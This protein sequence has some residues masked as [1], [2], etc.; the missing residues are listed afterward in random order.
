MKRKPMPYLNTGQVNLKTKIVATAN[1]LR[2]N[3]SYMLIYP[4]AERTPNCQIA[5][6]CSVLKI[7]ILFLMPMSLK[8]NSTDVKIGIDVNL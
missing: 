2:M 1:E 5:W 7:C 3:V 8:T 4:K 6:L